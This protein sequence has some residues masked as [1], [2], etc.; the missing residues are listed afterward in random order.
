[1]PR[2]KLPPTPTSSLDIQAKDVSQPSAKPGTFTLP[3]P[4]MAS[5]CVASTVSRPQHI[6]PATAKSTF[7][8]PP[9][10]TRSRRIIQMEPASQQKEQPQALAP[11]TNVLKRTNSKK[12]AVTAPVTNGTSGKKQPSSTS[13]A[14]KKM[15][16]KTAHSVIERRRRSKMN[17][18]FAVLKDMIPACKDQEMHKLAILSCV[19]DLKAANTSMVQPSPP[20]LHESV[21]PSYQEEEEDDLVDDDDMDEDLEMD[22]TP[23]ECAPEPRTTNSPHSLAISPSLSALPT[24]S[25]YASSVATLPSPSFR[26]CSSYTSYSHSASTSPTIL[27]SMA[28]DA[29]HEATAAL[30]MLNKDRRDGNPGTSGRSMSVKDLLS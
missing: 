9:P 14:G 12:G 27:P 2:V 28:Q 19:S 4:A 1:M 20:G 30:L 23:T 10:P 13:A 11:Q 8:L 22:D 24:S 5:A 16:R 6:L 26:P 15:A 29:D 21:S 18:E 25:S 7:E 17:E 3:P